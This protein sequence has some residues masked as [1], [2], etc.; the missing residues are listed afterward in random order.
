[1]AVG[2]HHDDVGA[3]TRADAVDMFAVSSGVM[4]EGDVVSVEP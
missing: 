1:M 4:V 3:G 2:I